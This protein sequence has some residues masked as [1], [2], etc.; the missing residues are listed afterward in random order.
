MDVYEKYKLQRVI[1]ASG[2]MTI[3]GVSKVS[4]RVAE[5]QKKGGQNFFVMKDLLKE[6]GSYLAHRLGAED[7]V[8]VSS[9]SAGIA[10]SVAAVIGQGDAYHLMHPYDSRYQRKEI[11]IPKGH[12]VNYGTS[13][14]LMIQQGGGKVVEA[15]YANE[16]APEHIAMNITENTAAIFYVKSHH[17]VQKSMLT[18]EEAVMVAKEHSVPLIIDAAAEEDLTKYYE[19]GCDLV[20]Y[21]GAKAIEGPSSGLVLGKE[22]LVSWVRMQ[23]SGL[24]RS[25]KIG[26]E[27][28]LG[29]VE[30]VDQYLDSGSES[31]E[32]MLAR[33]NPFID[34]LNLIPGIKAQCVQDGAGREIYRAS[35]KVDSKLMNA[36]ELIDRLKDGNTAVYTREYQ[37]NNGII[38]FDIRSVN[39]DE[40][41]VI[42]DKLKNVLGG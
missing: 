28:I 25:M 18:V 23:S 14:E 5:A 13:V 15:G 2:K 38:E 21:S 6:T 40:M 20:I 17:T 8:I 30:A 39:E 31:K 37:A 22:E 42:V 7:A 27:N 4:D 34:A 1:N 33:L 36:H 24:G 29:F 26:K 16:C 41:S 11:I 19:L 9:A 32:S 10:Q 35:V 3:L 12:N